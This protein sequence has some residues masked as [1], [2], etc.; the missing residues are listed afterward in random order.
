MRVLELRQVEVKADNIIQR[1]HV[2][3]VSLIVSFLL[4]F[5]YLKRTLGDSRIQFLH[6]FVLVNVRADRLVAREGRE[7]P[8]G[9]LDAFRVLLVQRLAR[10]F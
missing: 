9:L 1:V 4:I 2:Q 8:D 3:R 7:E 10:S 6:Q 5:N